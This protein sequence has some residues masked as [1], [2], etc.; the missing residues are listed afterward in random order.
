[1][2]HILINKD[3]WEENKFKNY[4]S[5]M[6]IGSRY[7]TSPYFIILE[8][9]NVYGLFR[10]NT[11]VRYFFSEEQYDTYSDLDLIKA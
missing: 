3:I 1:M 6:T 5:D 4:I 10:A 8:Y 9:F 2:G 7:S 11:R